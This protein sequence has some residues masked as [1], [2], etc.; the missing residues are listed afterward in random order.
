MLHDFSPFLGIEYCT[1][2]GCSHWKL[3]TAK[4]RTLAYHLNSLSLAVLLNCFLI[5][6]PGTIPRDT[7][8]QRVQNPMQD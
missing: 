1:F 3:E 6:S 7:N 4:T 8:V 5:D 2:M